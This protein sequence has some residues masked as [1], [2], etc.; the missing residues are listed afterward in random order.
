MA[1]SALM[2]RVGTL[3]IAAGF[4]AALA[5]L[6]VAFL[7]ALFAMQAGV[8]RRINGRSARA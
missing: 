7:I 5:L 4:G 3:A 1:A 6:M 8:S 2:G